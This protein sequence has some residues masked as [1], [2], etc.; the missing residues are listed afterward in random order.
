M[1]T[2]FGG[3]LKLGYKLNGKERKNIMSEEIQSYKFHSTGQFR[4]A[5]KNIQN[6]AKFKGLDD[7]G[8]AIIDET[9]VAPTI[10]YTGTTK[11]HGTN[12]SIVIHSRDLITFNSKSQTL[13]KVEKGEFTLFSDNSEFAQSMSRRKTAV[14]QVCLLAERACMD[15]YG[16]V[17]YPIKISG[18]WCG[19]GIQKGVGISFLEKKSLFI[20]GV[21]INKAW[22][23]L[24]MIKGI[25]CDGEGI[26]NIMD[27]PAKSV[28]IDFSNPAF[29][30]NELVQS[31]EDVEQ[32]C[33]VAKQL[34]VEQSLLGEG[35]VWIPDD[36]DLCADSGNWFKTKGEK[37]S[38]SKVK[39]VAAIC[40][41]KLGSIKSFVDY[42]CTDNRMQQGLDAI[43]IQLIGTVIGVPFETV[44]SK[45]NV[46]SLTL[47][48]LDMIEII[49]EVEEH[50]DLEIQDYEAEKFKSVQDIV[51][52]VRTYSNVHWE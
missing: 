10:S 31:T 25:S 51:D 16:D 24:D 45:S 22:L 26:Y 39:S 12:A 23:S 46:E 4:N 7:E 14:Q 52:Y 5:V 34:G 30:Q 35:L 33:P 50:F 32:E 13:G 18:E 15:K 17:E 20:F 27:F 11:L 47:D 37:H 2:L 28:V 19:Q 9:A 42:A 48:S 41:E 44:T 21:K 29:S 36:V 40:P 1:L 49:M 8:N 43:V 6:K 38:V 3:V